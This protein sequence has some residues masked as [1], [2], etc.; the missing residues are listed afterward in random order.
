MACSTSASAA[1]CIRRSCFRG[2]R[3]CEPCRKITSRRTSVCSCRRAS[4]L[5]LW[6]PRGGT[7][8]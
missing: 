8:R 4:D 2:L 3:T 1:G 6:G 5:P 7:S